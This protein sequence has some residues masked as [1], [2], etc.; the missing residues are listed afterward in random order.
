MKTD[1]YT[2]MYQLVYV[3]QYNNNTKYTTEQC[4]LLSK[5]LW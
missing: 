4:T 3:L 1:R 2:E 5:L